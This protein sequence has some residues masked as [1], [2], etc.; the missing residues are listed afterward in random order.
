VSTSPYKSLWIDPVV[1]E[2][3]AAPAAVT[4]PA[5][6]PPRRRRG[7]APARPRPRVVDALSAVAGLGLGVT[8][9]LGVTAESAGS[10]SAAGGWATAAGR[11]SGL[12]AMY[13]MVVV[14]LLVA[15]IPP[16]E[17]AIG[18]DRLV[19]WHRRLGPYPLYLVAAHGVLITVGYAQAAHD[20]LLHQLGQ[21][22]WTYPGFL[23][24]TV[25]F[26]LLV[27][28]GVASYRKARRRL[29]YETWWS[30]HLYTY[31]ALFLAFSHQIGTGA[32]F[33]GHPAAT[34]FWK[35][36]FW[37]T[38]VTVVLCRIGLPVWRTLRHRI[39]VVGVTPAG[40]D[41]YSVLLEG[42]R[43]D[44]LP[45]AGGQFLQWRFLRRGMWWQAHPYSLSAAP[46]RRHLRIT[47]KAL[48]DH[49]AALESLAPGTRVAVEGPYGAFT[50]D[51][52]RSD[53]VLL[54]G[55]GV[56]ST[57]IRALLEELPADA[58][59]VTVLRASAPAQVALHDEI[60]AD[61]RARGG[62]LIEL[63]GPRERVDLSAA[64]LLRIAP[65]LAE[66]DVFVCGP[67]GFSDVVV[68]AA[69]DAGVPG[70]HIH[71]ETFDF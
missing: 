56:G 48:G 25:G 62:R 3:V 53:R 7:R 11:V 54:V 37:G 5:A 50:A 10:L 42:R 71:R 69:R 33:V 20:G 28:A 29:A 67:D 68:A 43:L 16:L 46:G 27:T 55:A 19:G 64:A 8:I 60:A 23:A 35:V 61:V 59:V 17:R 66:R 65:D 21:L 49:S 9:A 14:V 57:P 36:L 32:S 13:A 4:A 26:V 58:D 34:L 24:A 30:V 1:A 47:V 52:R 31:L 40:P 63:T 2:P 70:D 12:V 18:M 39:R 51:H 6:T 22:L 44:R 41:M 38:A 45:V 15:R